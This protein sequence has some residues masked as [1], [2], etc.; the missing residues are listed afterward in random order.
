MKKIQWQNVTPGGNRTQA[1]TGFFSRSKTSDANIANSVNLR[2]TRLRSL[3]RITV[4]E[5]QLEFGKLYK[6][7]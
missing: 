6:N 1:A 7:N 3:M 5:I 2:K 4:A